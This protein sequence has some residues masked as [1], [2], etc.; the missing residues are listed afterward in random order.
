MSK[1]VT[2]VEQ[3]GR[4]KFLNILAEASGLKI[5]YEN[6]N[7]P[8][9]DGKTVYL[10]RP[11]SNWTKEDWIT[12]EHSAVHEMGHNV[13]EMRDVFDFIREK[14]I[15]MSSLCGILLNILDDHRQERHEIDAFWGRK[16]I[17]GRGSELII[18]R[19]IFSENWYVEDE[20]LTQHLIVAFFIWDAYL[21]EEWLSPWVTGIG[22]LGYDQASPKTQD[23]VDVLRDYDQEL[24]DVRTVEDEWE[25]IL[26][27]LKNTDDI[28][29]EEEVQKA[30]SGGGG[31]GEENPSKVQSGEGEDEVNADAYA[32]YMDML[33]H[34]HDEKDR[35][36]G[37]SHYSLTIDYGGWRQEEYVPYEEG[38]FEV[39]SKNELSKPTEVGKNML[40][41][42]VKYG[43]SPASFAKRVKRLLIT[44]S[45][46]KYIGGKK[47]GKIDQSKVWRTC[48]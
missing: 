1:K 28:D 10:P 2:A 44:F 30:T 19:N 35:D 22:Q 15:D 24:K 27:I 5:V 43:F 34:Q 32:K 8:R 47:R 40:E 42:E 26:K 13:P 48:L 9:T 21:R 36:T 31:D 46:S 39:I 23:L 4:E 7:L 11:L 38:D 20:D 6:K 45:K 41:H 12:F 17:I 37:R 18:P 29:E 25:L 16:N 14:N 33:F 3:K